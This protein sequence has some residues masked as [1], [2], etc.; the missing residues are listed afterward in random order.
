MKFDLDKSLEILERT[1]IALESL[2]S[3]LSKEWI[4]NN[5]G[6]ETW[7]PY[8]V[9]GH[10]IHGEN[11]DWIQR[12]EIILSETGDKK[13]TPFDRF[14]QFHES[15]GKTIDD[16]LSEFKKIRAANITTLRSWNLKESDF[17]KKGIHPSF[18]EV[19]LSQL[20]STWTAHDLGHLAQVARVMARQYK[21]EVGPWIEYLRILKD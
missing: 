17:S 12:M 11:T 10:L 14:A 20:L 15:K 6:G 1:P 18:G 8:D 9:M 19:T 5:E 21:E 7:S 13:F 4:E 2:L 3:G 16:L